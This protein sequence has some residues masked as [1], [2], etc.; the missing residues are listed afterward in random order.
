MLRNTTSKKTVIVRHIWSS[1]GRKQP[2]RR[3]LGQAE[4]ADGVGEVRKFLRPVILLLWSLVLEDYKEA[5]QVSSTERYLRESQVYGVPET[6]QALSILNIYFPNIT[7]EESSY[8]REH[9]AHS[10]NCLLVGPS[11]NG[12]PQTLLIDVNGLG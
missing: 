6:T 11:Q 8:N 12:F 7:T 10:L 4:C 1:L 5:M 2:P 3:I 9:I